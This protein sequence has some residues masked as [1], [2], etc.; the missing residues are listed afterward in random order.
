MPGPHELSDAEINEYSIKY[1]VQSGLTAL[2]WDVTVDLIR[3]GWPDNEELSVPGVYVTVNTSEVA[4]YELGS[5]GKQIQA[6]AYIYGANDSQ[7]TRLADTIEDQFRDIVP[8]YDYIDGNEDSPDISGYFETDSVR[9]EKIPT[10]S[11]VPDKQKWRALVSAFLRR[12]VA[13]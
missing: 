8:I 3:D 11:I 13:T 10:L 4:G 1:H 6:L 2:G 7:R 12:Q 5:H 9:W